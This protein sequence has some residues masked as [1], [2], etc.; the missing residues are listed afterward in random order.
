MP[1]PW[2]S[3]LWMLLCVAG[4][5]TLA[6]WF[7]K[8]V[9]GRKQTGTQNGREL[10]LL[11]AISVGKNQRIAVLR[12]GE[13]YFLLGITEQNISLLSELSEEEA[14]CFTQKSQ[15]TPTFME[16]FQE[17]LGRKFRGDKK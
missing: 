5:T 6:Y 2:G 12:A 9:V 7:T 14:Q 1:T 13:R 15:E 3:L 8:F 10:Q 17:Q 11:A 16:A 4:V